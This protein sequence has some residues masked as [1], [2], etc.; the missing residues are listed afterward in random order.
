[1]TPGRVQPSSP[2]ARRPAAPAP[3]RRGFALLAVLWT[4]LGVAMLALAAAASA[5]EGVA[6]A[7]NRANLARAAWRAEDCLERS[8]AAIAESLGAASAGGAD[9]S[10]AWRTLDA[11]VRQSP[12]VTAPV[13]DV[14]LRA[15]GE[16]VDLNAADGEQLRALLR[17]LAV[18]APRADSL[19]DALLDWRDEDEVQRPHGAERTWYDSSGRTPPRNGPL[20]DPHELVLVRGFATVAGLD[21][22]AWVEPGR[23][24]VGHAPLAVLATLPGFGEEA[25]ARVAERRARG[26]PDASLTAL[27]AELSPGARE[28]LGARYADL[29]R[30][31][32]TEPD[33]WIL[34]ARG[35]AGAPVVVAEIE[36]RLVRAGPRAAD[37]RKRVRS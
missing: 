29:V 4:V 16:S 24:A 9:G 23:V 15:A 21:R 33:A 12:L 1:M 17:V 26:A 3:G 5:R 19:A 10:G 36:V 32:T 35:A 27:A 18:P 25:L 7:R 34:T 2:G 6:A 8:R 13:C 28:Q 37:V 22:V 31:A 20:A 11:I 14:T 30:I